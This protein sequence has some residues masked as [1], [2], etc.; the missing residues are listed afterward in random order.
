MGWP[1]RFTA[2]CDVTGVSHRAALNW[3]FG[4]GWNIQGGLV[5]HLASHYIWCLIVQCCM[6]SL[7]ILCSTL[8]FLYDNWIPRVKCRSYQAFLRLKSGI[9]TALLLPHCLVKAGYKARP[10]SEGGEFDSAIFDGRIDK[11]FVTIS[12]SPKMY[13]VKNR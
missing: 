9:G 12:N 11:E 5:L 1:G 4:W 6:C 8:S 2:L 3:E 7:I 13:G 10:N